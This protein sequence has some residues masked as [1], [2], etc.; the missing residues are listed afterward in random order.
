MQNVNLYIRQMINHL[1]LKEIKNGIRKN[2]KWTHI[3]T[4]IKNHYF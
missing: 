4:V 3:S 1:D 2:K